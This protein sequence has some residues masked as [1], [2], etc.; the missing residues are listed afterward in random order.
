M[1]AQ[2][3]TMKE[4]LLLQVGAM[5]ETDIDDHLVVC[6]C[7]STTWCSEKL[8]TLFRSLISSL[9]PSV[10]DT[11]GWVAGRASTL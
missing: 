9:M 7:L 5:S 3:A 4:V 10:P 6:C 2:P 8:G 11:V 1:S